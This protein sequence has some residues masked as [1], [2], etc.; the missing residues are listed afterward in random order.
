MITPTIVSRGSMG[1]SEGLPSNLVPFLGAPDKRLPA[2]APYTGS[3]RY[4]PTCR[5]RATIT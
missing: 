4:R 3:P 5:S 1:V 2:Q